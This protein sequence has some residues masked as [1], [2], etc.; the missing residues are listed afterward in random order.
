MAFI[1][2]SGR[3]PNRYVYLGCSFRDADGNA[4][5]RRVR[6]GRVD[7][8]TGCRVYIDGFPGAREAGYIE[9]PEGLREK[10]VEE[11]RRTRALH[12]ELFGEP[13]LERRRQA[14]V[15][16][17]RKAPLFSIDDLETVISLEGGIFPI[18]GNA[19]AGAGLVGALQH[20]IPDSWGGVLGLGAFLA[21]RDE[22]LVAADIWAKG[23]GGPEADLSHP[24]VIALL[25]GL[26]L[27]GAR[28]VAK[29]LGEFGTPE[30]VVLY[31][32]GD[33]GPPLAVGA[34]SWLPRDP[35]REEG[36]SADAPLVLPQFAGGQ[37]GTLAELIA[38]AGAGHFV[39]EAHKDLTDALETLPPPGS[40]AHT[41]PLDGG[42]VKVYPK[43]SG[44]SPMYILVG[45]RNELPRRAAVS[46]VLDDPAAA[47]GHLSLRPYLEEVRVRADSRLEDFLGKGRLKRLGDGARLVKFVTLFLSSLAWKAGRS[48]E[49]LRGLTPDEILRELGGVRKVVIRRYCYTKALTQIQ[50]DIFMAFGFKR[51]EV[52]VLSGQARLRS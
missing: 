34:R 32:L 19:S 36:P 10:I 23:S 20:R 12:P 38:A 29:D 42:A 39:C 15:L 26:D 6:V 33:H 2:E 1:F 28:L 30:G 52:D 43:E 41:N 21:V 14:L 40:G 46:T 22:G 3:Q 13:A 31:P 51:W 24:G 47:L 49:A 7:V 4:R 9:V 50:K 18:L 44:G 25:E 37:P 48:S 35:F 45:D 17:R 11:D 8:L 27:A 5:N 16:R